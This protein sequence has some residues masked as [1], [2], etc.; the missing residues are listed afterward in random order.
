MISTEY[1]VNKE[2]RTIV[3]IIKTWDEVFSRLLK[4]GF[5]NYDYINK[6]CKYVGVAKCAAEDEWDEEFGRRLAEYR[7]MVAR[8]KDVNR[9]I[10]NFIR[11]TALNIDNLY[12]YGLIKDPHNPADPHYHQITI[13]EYMKNEAN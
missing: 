13:E 11:K 12:N 1:Q 4:Y 10:K 8:Q 5:K 9:E 3:C 2:K 7:A 6:S